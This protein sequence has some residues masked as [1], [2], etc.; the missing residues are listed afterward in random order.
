MAAFLSLFAF[1]VLLLF[2][3][4]FHEWGH[5]ITA[6][7]AGIKAS[8]FFIGFGPTIWSTRRGRPETYVGADGTT[9]TRPETEFGVKALPIGGF[10]RIVGM[11]IAEDGAPED[12]PRSFTA[13]L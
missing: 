13:R 9:M 5:Y 1:I 2:T 10:V 12:E 6:R 7:W 8:K 4:L 11:S 3:I